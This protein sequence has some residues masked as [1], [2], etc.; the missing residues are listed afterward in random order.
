MP[1]RIRYQGGPSGGRV[2]EFADTDQVVRIG[3]DPTS[4][5]VHEFPPDLRMV[6]RVHCELHRV[7]GRY[8]IMLNGDDAVFVDGRRIEDGHEL[9]ASA[10]V[11]LGENGPRLVIET[12]RRSDVPETEHHGGHRPG[13]GTRLSDVERHT[14]W[15]GPASVGALLVVGLVGA[16]LAYQLRRAEQMTAAQGAVIERLGANLQ[17]MGETVGTFGANLGKLAPELRDHLQTA[18]RSVYLVLARHADGGGERAIGTAWVVG[19]SLLA[20]NAHVAAHFAKVASGDVLVVRSNELQPR[21][22]VIDRV[23]IHPG[24]AAFQ[25]LWRH[26]VPAQEAADGTPRPLG[27]IP[28]CD[29]ATLQVADASGLAPALRLARQD[30]LDALAAGDVIGYVGYPME[31]VVSGRNIIAQPTPTTQVGRITAVTDVF[32]RG[33]PP[34]ERL[35]VQHS[36]PSAGGAS[37]SPLMDGD[38]DVVALHNAS[39]T[40]ASP[41]GRGRISTGVGINY[42]QRVDLLRE[43]LDG[44]ADELQAARL[45]RWRERLDAAV[46]FRTRIPEL[47]LG[48]WT[49]RALPADVAPEKFVNLHGVLD[50]STSTNAIAR[51]SLHITE[52]GV[53]LFLAMASDLGDNIEMAVFD[54]ARDVTLG[55]AEE[56]DGYPSVGVRLEKP[57]DI[58]VVIVGHR[59]GATFDL[60]GYRGSAARPGVSAQR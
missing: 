42:G 21:D 36:L 37:G 34:V 16:M 30:A 12:S 45:A 13:I 52:P 56:N 41:R 9:G 24:F 4:C 51:F 60:Y 19:S 10:D 48:N 50:E 2:V 40:I 6:G 54:S 18:S 1:L 25:E 14:R 35:V 26:Y 29:V 27:M 47:I 11:Q 5:P 22:F 3:R 32:L 58:A 44:R 15:L 20:T 57:G 46:S 59:A 53:Y 55:T 31:L 17:T 38:G 43:L 28:A 23:T 8:R 39:N 49:A 7:A 33:A